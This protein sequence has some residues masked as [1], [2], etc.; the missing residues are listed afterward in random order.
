MQVFYKT[1]GEDLLFP[2]SFAIVLMAQ[3]LLITLLTYVLTDFM[4]GVLLGA[5]C[6]GLI[7]GL[8]YRNFIYLQIYVVR[9]F[10]KKKAGTLGP[11]I[12]GVI[13]TVSRLLARISFWD[14]LDYATE[15]TI[16]VRA[17][18]NKDGRLLWVIH[19]IARV[20]RVTHDSEFVAQFVSKWTKTAAQVQGPAEEESTMASLF[21]SV[22]FSSSNRDTNNKV[23]DFG[24]RLMVIRNLHS[25]F[26]I[27]KEFYDWVLPDPNSLRSQFEDWMEATSPYVTK[28]PVSLDK[29]E[30]KRIEELRREGQVLKEHFAKADPNLKRVIPAAFLSRV[31]E[32]NAYHDSITYILRGDVQRVKPVSILFGTKAGTGKSTFM[33]MLKDF[34]LQMS[35]GKPLEH[36]N[37]LHYDYSKNA[38]GRCDGITSDHITFCIDDVL[39]TTNADQRAA[40]SQLVCRIASDDSFAPDQA[41]IRNKRT[42]ISPEFF[43]ATT[44]EEIH[45]DSQIGLV[46]TSAF[47]RRFDYVLEMPV[48]TELKRSVTFKDFKT[49]TIR[50]KKGE[51]CNENVTV[52]KMISLVRERWV[53]NKEDL[54]NRKEINKINNTYLQGILKGQQSPDISEESQI[55]G[56]TTRWI[57]KHFIQVKIENHPTYEDGEYWVPRVPISGYTLQPTSCSKFMVGTV[58]YVLDTGLN[59]ARIEVKSLSDLNP[60]QATLVARDWPRKSATAQFS[61]KF[62][63]GLGLVFGLG[64]YIASLGIL[65]VAIPGLQA[66]FWWY[67]VGGS[68][69]TL[70]WCMLWMHSL[71]IAAN[72]PDKHIRIVAACV[73]ALAFFMWAWS[74]LG[75]SKKK[76]AQTEAYDKPKRPP[77]RA[78][79]E[80]YAKEKRAP[81]R[82]QVKSGVEDEPPAEA[83]VQ[84]AID[85]QARQVMNRVKPNIGYVE[86]THESSGSVYGQNCLG[87]AGRNILINQHTLL[88]FSDDP[89]SVLTLWRPNVRIKVFLKSVLVTPVDDDVVSLY[90]EKFGDFTSIL[91]HFPLEKELPT[92]TYTS[93]EPTMLLTRDHMNLNKDLSADINLQLIPQHKY[94]ATK[95]ELKNDGESIDSWLDGFFVFFADTD[96][97]EC[98]GVYMALDPKVE[99]KIMAIHNASSDPAHAI[100]KPLTRE[101]V[102]AA[103]VIRNPAELDLSIAEAQAGIKFSEDDE[104]HNRA[105]LETPKGFMFYGLA[106]KKVWMNPV[107]KIHPSPMQ[108][109]REPTTFV[110]K[111][112]PWFDGVSPVYPRKEFFK[113]G[114][115]TTLVKPELVAQALVGEEYLLP[116]PNPKL[117][118]VLS[119]DE[120]LNG[121]AGTQASPIR[122]ETS[123]GLRWGWYCKAGKKPYITVGED[124]RMYLSKIAELD[125]GRREVELAQHP[126]FSV[127]KDDQKDERYPFGKEK[128]FR[129][130]SSDD[131]ANLI[132]FKKYFGAVLDSMKRTRPFGKSQVGIDAAGPHFNLMYQFLK[133]LSNLAIELDGRTWDLK[134]P[135]EIVKAFGPFCER[136]Y[137][138]H[139]PNENPV[140]AIIRRNILYGYCVHYHVFGDFVYARIGGIISGFAAT[141]E[142][143]GF[144]NR[145]SSKIVFSDICPD[146]DFDKNVRSV[147]YGDDMLAT[148]SQDCKEFNQISFASRAL[149][150]TGME[151]TTASKEAPTSY[152]IPLREASFI[153]RKFRR[154]D[155]RLTVVCGVLD[156]DTIMEIPLW[157]R[158]TRD[159]EIVPLM[160]Q[161]MISS[162]QEMVFHG[163]QAFED[164]KRECNSTL[165]RCG[166]EPLNLQFYALLEAWKSKVS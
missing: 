135:F 97:G 57:Q 16:G 117:T 89:T 33:H 82:A 13:D 121:V 50:Y 93:Y 118:A 150:L 10:L 104:A 120:A 87:V 74:V 110:A 46:K 68:L 109:T 81:K 26:R 18:K 138:L 61:L 143:N 41:E 15:V 63:R 24:A 47:L 66:M 27:L 130:V 156:K 106:E 55:Q 38:H 146:R 25:V 142:V 69:T 5:L 4:V 29:E 115:H 7:L 133:E 163:R 70:Y 139:F 75:N 132:I 77:R 35:T 108:K 158:T 112:Q 84:V 125:V 19:I 64:L 157:V 56:R 129:V 14:L 107:T 22:L 101:K 88:G 155:P 131:V 39:Q 162:L 72:G 59:S 51:A 80:A 31:S 159:K 83:Q 2:I 43:F 91:K 95:I 94:S 17:F 36:V 113:K 103:L 140:N 6:T 154:L 102:E 34:C 124:N 42:F 100:A 98:G 116:P 86:L 12:S 164:W 20:L 127:A 145:L 28:P 3:A 153:S 123:A 45:E 54:E 114:V 49:M 44:N 30:K 79:T 151:W 1:V 71:Q 85:K 105:S 58:H 134:L 122:H 11:Q 96:R 165:V 76:K 23:R 62:A 92:E 60:T 40:E 8:V 111:R 52:L 99:H 53:E 137:Q 65:F 160:R 32:F 21:S 141:A 119:N 78:E 37:H 149:A 67:I 161:G 148:V 73:C 9:F 136:F 147:Y 48:L 126:V 144:C 128:K 152:F 166:A 90:H